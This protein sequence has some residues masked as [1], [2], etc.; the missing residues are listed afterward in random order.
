MSRSTA[1]RVQAS[2]TV[3]SVMGDDEMTNNNSN[4]IF[5]DR[6]DSVVNFGDGFDG[7]G[8][9]S[10]ERDDDGLEGGRRR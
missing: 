7:E 5:S 4:N 1:E 9:N 3:C 8:G 2:A 6:F 10:D